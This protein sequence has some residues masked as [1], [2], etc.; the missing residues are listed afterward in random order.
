MIGETAMIV[1]KIWIDKK[2]RD[3]HCKK[4]IEME[5]WYLFGVIPLYV[6]EVKIIG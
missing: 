4:F 6:A 2:S 1:K 3:R 5:G